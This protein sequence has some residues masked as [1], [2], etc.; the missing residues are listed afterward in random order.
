MSGAPR[1][2]NLGPFPIQPAEFLKA[3]TLIFMVYL[4]TKTL[5]RTNK[6]IPQKKNDIKSGGKRENTIEHMHH[7]FRV[8]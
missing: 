1:W 2:L 7:A 4:T 3:F 8:I 6:I 5:N